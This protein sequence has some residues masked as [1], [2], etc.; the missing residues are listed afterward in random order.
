MMPQ[1]GFWKAPQLPPAPP[2]P[3]APPPPPPPT[4]KDMHE[5]MN[6]RFDT[7]LQLQVTISAKLDEVSQQLAGVEGAVDTM[8]HSLEKSDDSRPS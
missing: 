8:K 4:L 1:G 7:L 2:A 6:A 3:L 5:L